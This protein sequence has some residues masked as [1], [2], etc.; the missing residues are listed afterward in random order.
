MLAACDHGVLTGG[1]TKIVV[2]HPEPGVVPRRRAHV[3]YAAKPAACA[4]SST[5]AGS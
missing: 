3:I 1:G 2:A 4:T 5:S